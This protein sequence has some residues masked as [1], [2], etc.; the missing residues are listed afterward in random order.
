MKDTKG[1]NYQEIENNIIKKMQDVYE[2]YTY[3]I[4]SNRLREDEKQLFQKHLR[5][6]I[7][8][9]D[10]QDSL[11]FLS[12]LLHKHFQQTVYILIDEYDEVINSSY[13]KFGQESE[14]FESIIDLIRGTLGSALKQNQY[15]EKGVLTGVFRIAKA[16]LF[17]GLNNVAEYSL[18]DK[19]FSEYYGFTQDEVDDLLTNKVPDIVDQNDIKNWYNGYVFGGQIVYNPLSIMHCLSEG[20]I[21]DNYW[22]DSGDPSL[23]D[24][25]ML[26]DDNQI[27]L[28][29][30]LHGKSVTK[31]IYKQIAFDQIKEN[32]DLFYSLL[33]FTGYL[34]PIPIE[35]ELG[36]YKLSIP[37][38]QEVRKIY[39]DRVIQ[40][41]TRKLNISTSDYDNFVS[42]LLEEKME[43]FGEKLKHY[44]LNST[45]TFD[46]T[47]EKDYHNLMGGI[48]SPLSRK[49][50]VESNKES[51]YGR[52]DHVLVPKSNN[53]N[54]T[55][56][57][58]EYKVCKKENQLENK[59]KLGLEQIEKKLYDTQIKQNPQTKRIVKTC[60]S[61][62]KKK[63]VMR[64]REEEI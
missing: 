64:H 10:L 36:I 17:S 12:K 4:N 51:G 56:F 2:Q 18:L 45:S 11:H 20:G 16:S 57:I 40:W 27:E 6:E 13:V 9:A 26:S 47:E 31:R 55:A 53:P 28:Q 59:A 21:L 61:F 62:W 15:L 48:L 25:A 30:L 46:L 39:E 41:V 42:L 14:E 63:V 8:K 37:S 58:L 1:N 52:Y 38:N 29:T 43:R 5:G 7:N 3:L 33:V 44:L 24:Q 60:L 23:I 22:V 35:F 50:L 54:N 34:N 19:R 32:K 49:Y